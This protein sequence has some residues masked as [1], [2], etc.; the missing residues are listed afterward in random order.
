M[1][2][3][4]AIPLRL[5]R[6]VQES[7][8]QRYTAEG[9][10]KWYNEHYCVVC[11]STEKSASP[12]PR[13]VSTSVVVST[14]RKRQ[15][16]PS[17]SIHHHHHHPHPN[18]SIL[19]NILGIYSPLGPNGA[20]ISIEDR[21]SESIWEEIKTTLSEFPVHF[22]EH[23]NQTISRVNLFV[24]E[25]W[26]YHSRRLESFPPYPNHTKERTILQKRIELAEYISIVLVSPSD[27]W[28]LLRDDQKCIC[29]SKLCSGL[30]PCIRN[31]SR[32]V[33][34][35]ILLNDT[36]LGAPLWS[37]EGRNYD[38]CGF[39]WMLL[40]SLYDTGFHDRALVCEMV[41]SLYKLT[42][43]G[44]TEVD[45]LQLFD[46]NGITESCSWRAFK[47]PGL[48]HTGNYQMYYDEKFSI[49]A[50]SSS[51]SSS[52]ILRQNPRWYLRTHTSNMGLVDVATM[53]PVDGKP[54]VI[55]DYTCSYQLICA[56]TMRFFQ[57]K[58]LSVHRWALQETFR[59]ISIA[60]QSSSRG[61]GGVIH[62]RNARSGF[63][64]SSSV[65]IDSHIFQCLFV[66][67]I[68]QKVNRAYPRFETFVVCPLVYRTATVPLSLSAPRSTYSSSNNATRKAH[69][70]TT[71]DNI[72]IA[73]T[74][75]FKRVNNLSDGKR[76]VG[77]YPEG[78][79]DFLD[80]VNNP[81][82]Y[83][84]RMSLSTSR[85]SADEQGDA[86]DEVEDVSNG[87]GEE[88][89]SEPELESVDVI[90][91]RLKIYYPPCLYRLI[92]RDSGHPNNNE[93]FFFL[94]FLFD[95]KDLT[96]VDI[97]E[98]YRYLFRDGQEANMSF[99]EFY[100][101]SPYGVDFKHSMKKLQQYRTRENA[102][103]K[104]TSNT[105]CNAISKGF[106]PFSSTLYSP[107]APKT[108][109]S[110]HDDDD[111]AEPSV[112]PSSVV[113]DIEDLTSSYECY[114]SNDN[115]RKFSQTHLSCKQQCTER[116]ALSSGKK[117]TFLVSR[118]VYYFNQMVRCYTQVQESAQS[119][120]MQPQ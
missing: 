99:S 89:E 77:E 20:L 87:D 108:S 109:V 32:K 71:R 25:S 36:F 63:S 102:R 41:L 113:R 6:F 27:P 40:A 94:S 88:G 33:H 119:N 45:Q 97:A 70:R 58:S 51:S 83:Q 11:F 5:L 75:H 82:L 95:C 114:S 60:S 76:P 103:S 78:F 48:Q 44:W 67:Y 8:F 66:K 111:D 116:L 100:T 84:E 72:T 38:T 74:G 49:S 4:H 22:P 96:I 79:D 57:S 46:H 107:S 12:P 53:V 120:V 104:Y 14:H 92:G 1:D 43:F 16:V 110:Y 10:T 81:A 13:S 65:A 54:F 101:S 15:N 59:E 23:Q 2:I 29:S 85:S 105:C 9:N 50:T 68:N 7:E 86:Q 61:G 93:R 118:P 115:C 42:V 37:E 98:V 26:K 64:S 106:C 21:N 55:L 69:N 90:L 18:R 39:F 28:I 52:R 80:C 31:I 62:R 91:D 117:P 47:D 34:E 73:N 17:D 112:S 56:L 35:H 30:V 24:E 19:V 3:S